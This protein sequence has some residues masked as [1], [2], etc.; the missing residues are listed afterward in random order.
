ML[1]YLIYN[2]SLLFKKS[3][4]IPFPHGLLR[5]STVVSPLLHGHEAPRADRSGGPHGG[6]GAGGGTSNKSSCGQQGHAGL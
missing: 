5:H 4:F 2:I 3:W 6:C 1:V